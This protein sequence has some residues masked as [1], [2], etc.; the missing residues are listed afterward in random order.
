MVSELP[1]YLKKP[2]F[3][4]RQ[5]WQA[6]EMEQRVE[7]MAA[8]LKAIQEQNAAIQKAVAAATT[9]ESDG[10]KD[11]LLPGPFPL[12]QLLFSAPPSPTPPWR[13][14][15]APGPARPAPL[16]HAPPSSLP[17]V[18]NHLLLDWP[19]SP[20]WTSSGLDPAAVGV[21]HTRGAAPARAWPITLAGVAPS[22]PRMVG[23]PSGTTASCAPHCCSSGSV[24]GA[25]QA[26][27]QFDCM[28][29]KHNIGIASLSN[30]NLQ[31]FVHPNICIGIGAHCNTKVDL[32][33]DPM[34]FRG[35]QW[36]HP[37]KA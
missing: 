33:L 2:T 13:S 15:A 34:Q 9:M 16:C 8:A 10:V 25:A 32:V 20:A 28:A 3:T 26:N 27:R 5:Q 22:R 29:S 18:P 31:Y 6:D 12:S 21:S 35:S 37:N 1:D 4:T 24:H 30:S 14:A 23:W 19:C 7:E 11:A 36:R 17:A